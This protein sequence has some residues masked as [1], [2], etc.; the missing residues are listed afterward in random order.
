[1]RFHLHLVKNNGQ[2]VCAGG[3]LDTDPAKNSL[4]TCKQNY[5]CKTLH[6]IFE[7]V[8]HGSVPRGTN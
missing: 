3:N 1:M 2:T 4:I 6:K 7:C 8:M 5:F